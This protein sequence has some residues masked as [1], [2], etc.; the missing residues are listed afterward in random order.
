MN[1]R[2]RDDEEVT[3]DTRV[4]IDLPFEEAAKRLVR[5]KDD[6]ATSDDADDS[7]DEGR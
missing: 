4:K 5:P 1:E 2:P 3:R 7:E 6:H